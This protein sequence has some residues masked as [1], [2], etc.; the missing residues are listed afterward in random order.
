MRYALCTATDQLLPMLGRW[1]RKPLN[2]ANS[3]VSAAPPDL[4]AHMRDFAA[5]VKAVATDDRKRPA[6]R[7]WFARN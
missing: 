6:T 4:K 7:A 2:E 3:R 1:I 5:A